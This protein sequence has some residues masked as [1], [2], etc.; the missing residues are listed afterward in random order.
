MRREALLNAMSPQA[1]K[2]NAL[3]AALVVTAVA[4]GF[5]LAITVAMPDPAFAG[6]GG[7][8]GSENSAHATGKN[9]NGKIASELKWRNSAHASETALANASPNSR[10]GQM[11]EL[12]R[13]E[14][15][16]AEAKALTE[17]K[18]GDYLDLLNMTDEEKL[19]AYGVWVEIEVPSEVEGE[20]PT[21]EE[22]FVVDEDAY[23]ADLGLAYTA[24]QDA[25]SAEGIAQA[26]RD[27]VAG[28]MGIDDLTDRALEKLMAL[29]GL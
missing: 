23:N 13:V 8:K 12:K 1:V 9:E 3:K 28:P 7:V 2:K 29:L 27:G 10:P 14:S 18:H 6:K 21:I 11:R 4:G 5:A 22:V 20:P 26:E 15:E 17:E 24:W 25:L 16:L 19:A